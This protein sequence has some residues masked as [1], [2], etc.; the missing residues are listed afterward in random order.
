MS[1]LSKNNLPPLWLRIVIPGILIIAWFVAG[2]FGGPTFGKIAS[3]SSNDLSTYLPASSDS[4]KVQNLE[5]NFYASSDIPAIVVFE[6]KNG[7]ARNTYGAYAQLGY[8]FTRVSGVDQPVVGPIPS[9]DGKAIEYIVPVSAT[10][11]FQPV[12]ANLRTLVS[13]NISAG[14]MVM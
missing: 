13:K 11:D 6:A 5:S 8:E 4:T 12:V 10:K 1:K 14:V 2:A 3:V 7:I 9:K